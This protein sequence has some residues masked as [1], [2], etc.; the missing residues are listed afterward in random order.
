ML[1]STR[2]HDFQVGAAIEDGPP[3]FQQQG[4]DVAVDVEKLLTHLSAIKGDLGGWSE[5]AVAIRAKPVEKLYARLDDRFYGP[6]E[7]ESKVHKSLRAQ[8]PANARPRNPIVKATPIITGSMLIK[9]TKL[10]QASRRTARQAAGVEM[11]SVVFTKRHA[12]GATAMRGSSPYA[13]SSTSSATSVP[14]L[15]RSVNQKRLA[16]IARQDF[17]R[18]IDDR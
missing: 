3:E 13:E 2:V 4:G 14:L 11:V 15:H 6:K 10:A 7:W 5:E 8:F 1:V 16:G 12:M 17:T 9:D 18:S